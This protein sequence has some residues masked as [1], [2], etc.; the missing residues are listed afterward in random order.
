MC[1]FDSRMIHGTPDREKRK[2]NCNPES[3]LHHKGPKEITVV[4]M[5][6]VLSHF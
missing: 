1:T 3:R 2:P 5:L 6:I 4:F